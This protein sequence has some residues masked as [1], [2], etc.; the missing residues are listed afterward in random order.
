MRDKNRGGWNLVFGLVLIF[1]KSK[2]QN[3]AFLQK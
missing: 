3:P 2:I 1:P